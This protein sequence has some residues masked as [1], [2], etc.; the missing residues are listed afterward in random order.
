MPLSW[1]EAVERVTRIGQLRRGPGRTSAGSRVHPAPEHDHRAI[2]VQLA[3]VNQ[4]QSRALAV[5][6]PDW[7]PAL[8]AGIGRIP[9]L[10]VRVRFSSPA[11]GSIFPAQ[12]AYRRSSLLPRCDPLGRPRAR[13]VPDWPAFRA[14]LDLLSSRRAILSSVLASWRSLLPGMHVL[15][16]HLVG[17]AVIGYADKPSKTQALA[18]V[19]AAAVTTDLAGISTALRNTA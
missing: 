6:G 3:P 8:A 2:S 11:P 13:C 5:P 4:G 12:V 14:P 15:A 17:I 10:I 9:K 1:A 18:G 19:Q 7:S 16:G